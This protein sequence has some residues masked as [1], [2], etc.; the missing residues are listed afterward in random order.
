MVSVNCH[1]PFVVV[2]VLVKMG[3]QKIGDAKFEAAQTRVVVSGSPTNPSVTLPLELR[4]TWLT[5]GATTV[6]AASLLVALP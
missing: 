6:S 5:R 4:A 2:L 1:V 3:C